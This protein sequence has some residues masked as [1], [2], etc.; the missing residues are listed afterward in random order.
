[1]SVL[2]ITGKAGQLVGLGPGWRKMLSWH[3]FSKQCLLS[4]VRFPTVLTL[5]G[6]L[7]A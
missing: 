3:Y 2:I 7:D 6:F 1:M 4:D 5:K